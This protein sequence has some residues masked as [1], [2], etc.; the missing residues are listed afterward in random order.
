MNELNLIPFNSKVS[1]IVLNLLFLI[2]RKGR[3]MHL[4]KQSSKP[5]ANS[6]VRKKFKLMGSLV[7]YKHVHDG[8][9]EGIPDN[10]GIKK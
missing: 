5:K 3:T 7:D 9:N 10:S 2:Q 8:E 4:L 6:R 1:K